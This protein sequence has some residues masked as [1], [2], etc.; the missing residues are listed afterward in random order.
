[1]VHSHSGGLLNDVLEVRTAWEKN[2]SKGGKWCILT[3]YS[4]ELF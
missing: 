3:H 2:E 4:S 1:M